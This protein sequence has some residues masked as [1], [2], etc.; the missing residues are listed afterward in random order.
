MDNGPLGGFVPPAP[1]SPVALVSPESSK[2]SRRSSSSYSRQSLKS[3]DRLLADDRDPKKLQRLVHKLYDNLKFEKDRADYADHRASEAVSYLKS[4][5][6]DKLRALRE[7]SRLEEELKLY[8]IQYEEAQKEIFRA[9]SVIEEVDEKRFRAEKEAADARSAARRMRDE[10]NIIKAQEEG[11]RAGLEEGFRKGREMGY[12][13][14]L[15]MAQA[16]LDNIARAGGPAPPSSSG[17]R[18]LSHSRAASQASEPREHVRGHPRSPSNAPSRPPTAPPETP[19]SPSV[20]Q[21]TVPPTSH[22]VQPVLEMPEEPEVIRPRSYRAPSPPPHIAAMAIPPDNFIPRLEEDNMIHLPPPHE[23]SRPPPTPESVLSSTLPGPSENEEPRMIRPMVSTNFRTTPGRRSASP[24]S[25]STTLSHMDMVTNPYNGAGRTPMS[26]IPE[27]LSQEGSP[28]AHGAA[29]LVGQPSLAT[30]SMKLMTSGPSEPIYTRPRTV[31]ATSS[32]S[33]QP[34][35]IPDGDRRPSVSNSSSPAPS[36]T[37]LPPSVSATGSTGFPAAIHSGAFY[38]NPNTNASDTSFLPPI[39]EAHGQIIDSVPPANQPQEI[40]MPPAMLSGQI[41]GEWSYGPENTSGD[42]T[43]PPVIPHPDLYTNVDDDEEDA[44]SSGMGSADS[45]MTPP[46]RQEKLRSRATSVRS[47]GGSVLSR[48]TE[49]DERL[50]EINGGSYLSLL[51]TG[52]RFAT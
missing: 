12:E 43:N 8:K 52:G 21:S 7:I 16:E 18:V 39:P 4:I 32:I 2:S 19:T 15:K 46:T 1:V 40:A 22:P 17:D 6:E 13:E 38:S 23:F 26:I 9:Q 50:F 30:Q 28:D 29:S 47:A 27:S 34:P 25:A 37:V 36:I 3:L 31:S 11:R 45:F 49:D 41:P 24:T 33:F 5:C 35:V 20:P 51:N 44:V 14:G 42:S 48:H 10:I